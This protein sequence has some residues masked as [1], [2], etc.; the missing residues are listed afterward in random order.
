MVI[1]KPY[2]YTSRIG[3]WAQS[4][5]DRGRTC[6]VSVTWEEN[7][8]RNGRETVDGGF[9]TDGRRWR[10][11]WQRRSTGKRGRDQEIPIDDGENRYR[12][13]AEQY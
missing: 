5:R 13:N 9:R 3:T 1:Y 4:N 7:S 6:T 12:S 11:V 10:I 2:K 8:N